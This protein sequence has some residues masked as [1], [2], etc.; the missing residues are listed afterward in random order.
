[1]LQGMNVS[2]VEIV[3]S[4]GAVEALNLSLQAVTEQGDWVVVEDPCFYGA[5]PALE[6]L[7][8]K[9]S[10]VA[11]DVSDG[12]DPTALEAALQHH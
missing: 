2:P 1:A 10:P 4:P 9:A 5:L 6:R 3:I 7:R 11:P 8:S 12:I